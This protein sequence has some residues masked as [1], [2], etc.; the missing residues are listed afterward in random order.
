MRIKLQEITESDL[1]EIKSIYDY[2]ILNSTA[3]F[4]TD[5]I[6]IE[7]LKSFL[8]IHHPVYKTYLIW[9]DEKVCG[10]GYFSH[11]KPRQAYDRTSELTIYLKPEFHGKGIGKIALNLLEDQITKTNIKVLMGIITGDNA[12][13]IALFE[14]CGYEKCA[15]YKQVGEK[16]GKILDVVAYQKLI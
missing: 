11:F 14:K 16:F 10:Y 5:K 9:C 15:H 1:N 3:T 13:S 8:P 12:G 4:H 2:Y 6:T 7:E